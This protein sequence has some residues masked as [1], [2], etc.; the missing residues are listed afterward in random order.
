MFDITKKCSK[1]FFH[2]KDSYLFHIFFFNKLLGA[3]KK[4]LQLGK[5]LP[6][7]IV[8]PY[9]TKLEVC[10]N[11]YNQKKLAIFFHLVDSRFLNGCFYRPVRSHK[12]EIISCTMIVTYFV[13]TQKLLPEVVTFG[14]MRKNWP[15]FS[16]EG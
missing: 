5:W 2:W 6:K 9:K 13:D 12:F 16:L 14:S 4:I 3:T 10:H 11:H 1:S 7:N 15:L 8:E